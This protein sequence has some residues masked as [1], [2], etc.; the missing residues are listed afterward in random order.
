M[1]R[2]IKNCCLFFTSILLIVICFH[3]EKANTGEPL[4]NA[5]AYEIDDITGMEL[6]FVKGGCFLMGDTFGDGIYNEKPVHE[7]CV[8]DFYIGKYEVTN[9]EFEQFINETGYRTKAEKKGTSPGLSEKGIDDF[10]EKSGINWRHPLWPSDN[11]TNKMNHPV[12]QVSWGDAYQYIRWLNK[13]CWLKKQRLRYRFPTEAEWEFAARSRG[14][15]Y[16]YSW[17]NGALSGNIADQSLIRYCSIYEVCGG[18]DDGY[19]YTAPVGS[20]SANDLGLYDMSGNVWE[21][22]SDRYDDKYY[23]TGPKNNPLGAGYDKLYKV[24]RGGSW[25]Y[26]QRY[27]RA[28]NRDFY[29]GDSRNFDVGFRLVVTP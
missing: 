9:S 23:G 7:V 10:G 6:V 5:I 22:C 28:S 14:K 26:V 3:V 18:Y 4:T 20:F 17:G 1:K 27:S 11:I 16:K 8:D 21:W 29:S 19:V 13:I 12:V 25:Y 2:T 15:E 24:A